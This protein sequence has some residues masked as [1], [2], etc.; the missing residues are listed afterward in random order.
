MSKGKKDPCGQEID[1]VVEEFR[2]GKIGR[3]ECIAKLVTVGVAA[4]LAPSLLGTRSAEATRQKAS[5]SRVPT[6]EKTVKLDPRKMKSA[7]V[8]NQLKMKGA[9][10]AVR[11]QVADLAE[12]GVEIHWTKVYTEHHSNSLLDARGQIIYQTTTPLT[13]A[14]MSL[15]D[16]LGLR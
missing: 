10:V 13:D 12:A 4:S 11:E 1:S 14:E 2:E 15:I 8:A 16:R 9:S 6:R 7:E 5:A 3:R